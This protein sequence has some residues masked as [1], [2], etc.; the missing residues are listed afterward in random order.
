MCIY[1]YDDWQFPE[2]RGIPLISG[3]LSHE[4]KTGNQTD[5]SKSP[6]PMT[7]AILIGQFDFPFY[8]H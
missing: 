1:D 6:Y 5:H 3:C 4:R 2:C 7:S 8:V